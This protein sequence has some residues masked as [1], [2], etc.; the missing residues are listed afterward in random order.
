MFTKGKN[1]NMVLKT[2]MNP[3]TGNNL[4]FFKLTRDVPL[5]LP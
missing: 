1:I 5:K 4:F 2:G 3:E